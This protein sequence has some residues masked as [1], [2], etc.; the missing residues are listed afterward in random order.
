MLRQKF[1]ILE[2]EDPPQQ[3]IALRSGR[4]VLW[5]WVLILVSVALWAVVVSIL[6]TVF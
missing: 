4:R 1:S 2:Q 5:A 3:M 6:W